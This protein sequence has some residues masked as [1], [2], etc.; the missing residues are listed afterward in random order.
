MIIKLKKSELT[1]HFLGDSTY[2]HSY[3]QKFFY[4]FILLEI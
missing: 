4:M 2:E 1:A 3:L